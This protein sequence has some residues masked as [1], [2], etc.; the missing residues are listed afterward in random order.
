M[1]CV[2][3]NRKK[4]LTKEIQQ[5]GIAFEFPW[6]WDIHF[7]LMCGYQCQGLTQSSQRKQGCR[8]FSNN[9]T[10]MIKA[11]FFKIQEQLSNVMYFNILHCQFSRIGFNTPIIVK[12]RK[13]IGYNAMQ[14]S[15]IFLIY[16]V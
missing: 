8:S 11:I 6:P 10:A 1:I 14:K 16:N 15:Q 2:R 9:I 4:I 7:I 5:C 13:L 3:R 12:R